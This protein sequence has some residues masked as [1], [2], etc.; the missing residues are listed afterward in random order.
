MEQLTDD[1]LTVCIE[2]ME[3]AA[4]ALEGEECPACIGQRN[5]VPAPG[6]GRDE[7]SSDEFSA[8]FTRAVVI[9]LKGMIEFRPNRAV[10]PIA[11]TEGMPQLQSLART[12]HILHQDVSLYLCQ[13]SGKGLPPPPGLPFLANPLP[14]G[15]AATTHFMLVLVWVARKNGPKS[16]YIASQWLPRLELHGELVL[17]CE[18]A[19]KL[20]KLKRDFKDRG[21]KSSKV[22]QYH[23]YAIMK[24]E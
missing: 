6:A 3:A 5:R 24:F 19:Q 2:T 4:R 11:I 9:K 23:T 17:I 21:I 16:E 14:A 13:S 10:Y 12:I 22:E 1:D 15:K 8:K 18:A 7:T 20:E